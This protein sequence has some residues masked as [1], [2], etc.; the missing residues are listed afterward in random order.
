MPT[1]E[2]VRA[3]VEQGLD[4]ETIGTRLGVPAGQA[5]LIGTGM[6]ADGGETYTE[7]E[8]KR[9]GVLPTAQHLL[10]IRAENP[11]TK[12][13]VLDWIKARTAADPQMQE[14]A[15]RRTAEPPE[16]D[17]SSGDHD[18]LVVLT[19][20]HNQVKYLQEQLAALPGRTSGGDR[21]HQEQRRSIVDM[22]TLR[23]SQHEA[24]EEEYFWPAVRKALPGGDRWADDA[25]EQE[26]E[27]KDTLAALGRLDPGTDEFDGTVEK[28]V[29]LLRKHVAYEERLFLV[30]E[31]AM[32]DEQRRELGEK[33]LAAKNLAPT[34][35]D[36]PTAQ[37]V[38]DPDRG[39]LGW[40]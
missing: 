26:Q 18:V 16:I 1:R 6:P 5:Y 34:R 28:L 22:I 36:D 11:T 7:E 31:D 3:L 4:Y 17:D 33:I 38:D 13:S 10:G 27:G 2:Q 15:R 23:L 19:R 39:G 24:V 40:V 14:A 25:L 29:L 12:R 9:P 35:P 37:D 32:S 21:A 30:L 20:D 8:R